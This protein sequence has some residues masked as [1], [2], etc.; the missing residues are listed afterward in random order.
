VIDLREEQKEHEFDSMLVN[1]E[2]VSNETHESELHFEK[3]PEQ[4]I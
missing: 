1:S 2:F 4:R 3:H